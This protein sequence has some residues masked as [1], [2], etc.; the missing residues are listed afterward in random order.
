MR[1]RPARCA[2]TASDGRARRRS[3]SC[4]GRRS[5][6]TSGAP[7][8]PL[9]RKRTRCSSGTCLATACRK[10]RS[11]RTS[12]SPRRVECS[13]SCWSTGDWTSRTWSPTTSVGRSRCAPRCCT[14]PGI[15][16]S[17]SSIRSPSGRGVGHSSG[18][19]A[20]ARA[21]DELPAALHA[22]LV[23]AHTA[24]ASSPG[25]ADRVL[26]QLLEPWLGQDGQPAYYR[27][28]AQAEERHTDE[29]QDRYGSIAI[30]VLVC[31]GT[32]DAWLPWSMGQELTAAIPNARF[33]RIDG[34]GHLV[35]EDAPA[36]L[37]AL[38]VEFLQAPD[39][40]A[41]PPART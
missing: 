19:L 33:E 18:L 5:R 27:Q 12:R 15:D 30:P 20:T 7:S 23:R 32:D 14:A 2:G 16:D 24:Q 21:F 17:C 10:S 1:A 31:W 39:E 6:R 34:A 38:I 29:I 37:T 41:D 40:D 13:S 25:L 26:D 11:D 28:I 4:M 9:S 8:P 35:Q 36:E 22:A 3:C